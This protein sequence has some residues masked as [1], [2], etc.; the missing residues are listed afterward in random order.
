VTSTVK[1]WIVALACV[2]CFS[3]VPVPSLAQGLAIDHKELS[4]V[5]AE[6]FPRL[7][8]CFTPRSQVARARV[9]FRSEGTSRWYFVDMTSDAPCFRGILPKPS[10]RLHRFNYYV[11]VM[12]RA[13]REAQTQEYAPEVVPNEASCRKG[14]VAPFLSRASVVV[15]SAEGAALPAGFL[16]GG[17]LSTAAIVV[18]GAAVVGGGVAVGVTGGGGG[19]G[20]GGGGPPTLP[21]P[22]PT[23]A[24]VTTSPATTQ[25]GPSTTTLPGATTTTTTTTPTTTTLTGPPTTTLPGATTT[26]TSTSTTSTTTTTTTLPS[27]ASDLG[28]PTVQFLTPSNGTITLLGPVLLSA[29]A[30]DPDGFPVTVTYS[31]GTGQVLGTS[32][33]APDYPVFW[34]P[35]GLL[36][37]FSLRVQAV[38]RCG[39]KSAVDTRSVFIVGLPLCGLATTPAGGGFVSQLSAP[40]GRGQVIVNGTDGAFVGPGL[41]RL[42]MR[43]PRGPSQ[44]EATLVAGGSGTW[45]FDLSGLGVAG[46]LRV[47]AGEVAQVGPEQVV[48]R[49]RGLPGERIVFVFRTGAGAARP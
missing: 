25:A 14:L 32:T 24:T 35:C 43:F 28:P 5:V 15:G 37:T 27:C 13:F 10:R 33:T 26:T 30:A 23:T 42:P 19:D 18:G 47:V 29:Q 44:V 46:S 12:D 20:T 21:G 34:Q 39:N 41:A 4:C 40:A 2:A 16:G 1:L 22:T 9:Y 31:L 49:L 7:V 3:A 38:D 11:S 45:R 17:G 36:P 6:K 48:F 8:A